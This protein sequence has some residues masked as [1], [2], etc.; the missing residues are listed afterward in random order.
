MAKRVDE[1][2]TRASELSADVFI[3][4]PQ[5]FLSETARS[6][7]AIAW[8]EAV[9]RMMGAAAAIDRLADLLHRRAGLDYE[10]KTTNE[11][12]EPAKFAG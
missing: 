6:P 12:S 5:I 11:K 7:Q 10:R 2:A 4:A 9:D 8:R 1:L 3:A